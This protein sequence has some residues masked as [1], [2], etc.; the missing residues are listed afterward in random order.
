[1]RRFEVQY[2]SKHHLATRTDTKKLSMMALGRKRT[3]QLALQR[4]QELS[5][6]RSMSSPPGARGP[7]QRRRRNVVDSLCYGTESCS[8]RISVLPSASALPMLTPDL[9]ES[10]HPLQV[11]TPLRVVRVFI[12]VSPSGTDTQPAQRDSSHASLELDWILV[13]PNVFC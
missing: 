12:L 6:S 13:M 7:A 5:R 10:A 8:K 11:V 2:Y 1:L 3:D 4:H 9:I